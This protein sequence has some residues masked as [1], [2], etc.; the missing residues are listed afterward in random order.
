VPATKFGGGLAANYG[1]LRI[2]LIGTG[3]LVI[4]MVGMALTG[5]PVFWAVLVGILGSIQPG[6]IMAVGTLSARPEN[7]AVG[8]ALFYSLYYAGGAVGPAVCGWVA[9]RHGGPAGGVLAAAAIS[10]LVVPLFLLHRKLAA[11]TSRIAPQ[12][13]TRPPAV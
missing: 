2:L 5:M 6:I 4:G 13:S 3:V 7:R 1:A 10:A 8:M 12:A 9:D 11:Q